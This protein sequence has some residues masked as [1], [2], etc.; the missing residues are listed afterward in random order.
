M[1]S[2]HGKMERMEGLTLQETKT[3]VVF[4]KFILKTVSLEKGTLRTVS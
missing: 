1:H 4:G 3:S 2:L